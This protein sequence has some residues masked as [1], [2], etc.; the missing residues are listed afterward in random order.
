[1]RQAESKPLIDA[2]KSWLEK[3]GGARNGGLSGRAAPMDCNFMA[4]GRSRCHSGG[5]K[6]NCSGKGYF[7]EHFS[8]PGWL[9]LIAAQTPIASGVPIGWA[10]ERPERDGVADPTHKR[11]ETAPIER[12]VPGGP[13]VRGLTDLG[14]SGSGG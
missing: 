2:L 14:P 11:T 9:G 3:T 5:A 4:L 10:A 13:K 6:N 7:D 1:V 12:D 8:S